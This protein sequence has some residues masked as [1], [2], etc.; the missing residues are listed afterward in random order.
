MIYI[1]HYLPSARELASQVWMYWSP[2]MSTP[3][4][5]NPVLYVTLHVALVGA[6]SPDAL[7]KS[8]VYRLGG[9]TVYT[10]V[11]KEKL[12]GIG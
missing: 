4:L 1:W 7:V 2:T 8:K 6:G 9:C 3:K 12:A 5:R 10:S 11:D